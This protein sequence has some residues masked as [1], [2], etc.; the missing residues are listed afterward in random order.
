MFKSTLIV[1]VAASAL[2]TASGAHAQS[3][4]E[5]DLAAIV[6]AQ[7]RTIAALEARLDALESKPQPAPAAAAVA[8]P[9]APQVAAAAPPRPDL[10]TDW[11][12]GA[13]EFA[14]GGASFRLRG[15]VQVDA[16][17]TSGSDFADRNISGTELR[18]IRLGAEGAISPNVRYAVEAELTDNVVSVRSANIELLKKFGD[19][20]GSLTIGQRLNDR[21]LDG[22]SGVISVPFVER[23][24][25]GTAIGAQKGSFGVGLTGRLTGSSWHMTAAITGEDL[26]NAGDNNDTFTVTTRAHWNPVKTADVILHLG[27]WAF[28]ENYPRTLN[29]ISRNAYIAGH[30]ND[31]VRSSSGALVAPEHGSAYGVEAG[32]FGRA[33]IYAEAGRRTVEGGPATGRYAVDQNAWSLAGGWFLTPD[34]AGYSAKTGAWSRT[35]VHSPVTEGGTGAWEV[36]ARYDAY[37]FTDAPTGGDATAATLGLNWY[38][39]SQLRFM[40]NATR[41][42]TDNR[43]GA[44]QGADTGTT[45][46]V[47]SAL[48]F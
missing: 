23:N 35:T 45:V 1:S 44:F 36:L 12:K 22:A 8:T 46:V 26:S 31:L 24:A 42:E 7:A 47:R 27:G 37:D 2:A 19:V 15:R 9:P 11:S 3:V 38:W 21:S 17:S 10:R 6:Q 39:T 13:P 14:Q 30:F 43:T 41:W 25:V 34:K 32:A 48:S 18:A 16:S 33:W 5:A 29:S 20:E 28:Y 4:S 40:L